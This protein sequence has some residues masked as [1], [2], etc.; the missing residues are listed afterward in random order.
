MTRTNI[1]AFTDAGCNYPQY[2]SVNLEETGDVSLTV[3]Q[4]VWADGTEGPTATAVLK[5]EQLSELTRTLF[6]FV[7]TNR[8]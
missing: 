8:A 1:F 6:S 5:P 7:C 2:V 3:R 4:A